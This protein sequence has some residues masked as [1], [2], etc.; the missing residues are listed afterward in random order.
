M[1]SKILKELKEKN[2]KAPK[3]VPPN[4]LW[5]HDKL[6]IDQTEVANVHWQE[7]LHYIKKDSSEAY[8]LAQRPDSMVF[9][10]ICH[11]APLDP[12]DCLAM[13]FYFSEPMFRFFPVVG[14]SY[15]QVQRYCAWRSEITTMN[16]RKKNPKSKIR[17][18]YRLPTE[19]EWEEAAQMAYSADKYPYGFEKVLIKPQKINTKELLKNY[20]LSKEDKLKFDL[21]LD[22]HQKT[23]TELAFNLNDPR[24]GLPFLQ[25]QALEWIY[26]RQPIESNLLPYQMIGNVAE[27]LQEEN[28]AKGGSWL[29]TLDEVSIK[30]RDS[31]VEPAA[32]LGFRCVCEVIEE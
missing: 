31:Y 15:A 3:N 14:V 2:K 28:I 8:E 23:G 7:Y 25:R 11:L 19:K 20:N 9:Y 1:S 30:K 12:D 10:K 24:Y 26:Q 16:Y 18:H 13:G 27:M 6:F 21:M 29:H 4:G 22:I 17:F 5:L 32:W